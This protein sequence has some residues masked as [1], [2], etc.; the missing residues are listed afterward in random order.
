MNSSAF[1]S[2]KRRSGRTSTFGAMAGRLGTNALSGL[3]CIGCQVASVPSKKSESHRKPLNSGGLVMLS[4]WSPFTY[5][6]KSLKACVTMTNTPYPDESGRTVMVI[7]GDSCT[8]ALQTLPKI[9][10]APPVCSWRT[11][12]WSYR[13]V[14]IGDEG[15]RVSPRLQNRNQ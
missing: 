7:V 1:G 13:T 15:G 11:R 5:S 6:V 2:T 14:D 8:D 10:T 4:H 9:L 12:G 3:L